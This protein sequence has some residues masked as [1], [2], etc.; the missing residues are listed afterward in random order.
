[1]KKRNE[2]LDIIKGITIFLVVLGHCVVN[3]NGIK[4]IEKELFWGD[5][6][7]KFIYSFHMPLFALI[8]GYFLYFSVEK[9]NMRTG[10]IKKIKHLLPPIIVFGIYR[11][12]LY[13]KFFLEET[14]LFKFFHLIFTILDG[15]WFLH[16]IL[17]FSIIIFI[18]KNVFKDSTKVYVIIF[19]ISLV[20]PNV[21]FYM[22]T[23]TILFLYPFLIGGY[24]FAKYQ[25]KILKEVEKKYNFILSLV[26][27]IF[28]SL[29]FLFQENYYIYVSGLNIVKTKL[30]VSTLHQLYINLF[31]I[32][33][34]LIGS[35]FILL[36]F[37]KIYTL[38]KVKKI[39]DTFIYMGKNSLEI[40][41]FQELIIIF[42]LKP[43]S[44]NFEKSYIINF[45]E[46]I[47]V[48]LLCVFINEILNKYRILKEIHFGTK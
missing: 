24:F 27:L 45:F 32:S 4:F 48:I 6:I 16:S 15:Y 37:Y 3:G 14:L 10:I 28:G 1:M 12:F 43:L 9:Y 25:E 42:I 35:I 47:I 29:L 23:S 39:Y 19:L 11:Y 18:V 13:G 30:G 7:Y 41:C 40:Y 26:T 38:I 44:I 31:R 22:G 5:S 33:A 17:Y 21:V 20:I 8:S 2:F 34:G 36:V 46:T